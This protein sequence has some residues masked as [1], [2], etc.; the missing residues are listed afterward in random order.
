MELKEIFELWDADAEIRES[1]LAESAM[2]QAKLHGKWHRYLTEERMRLRTLEIEKAK[3]YKTKRQYFMGQLT[4]KELEELGLPQFKLKI[5]NKDIDI[6]VDADEEYS[7][8]ILKLALVK[9]KVDI[10][11]SIVKM[12][13]NRNFSIKTALDAVKFRNGEH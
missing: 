8:M 4:Q 3:L 10:L 6:H 5:L 12:I 7:K 1:T 13:M 2:D 11:E 9:E